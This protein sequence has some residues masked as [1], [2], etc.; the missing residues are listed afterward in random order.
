[1]HN[2][3]PGPSVP[4]ERGGEAGKSRWLWFSALIFIVS[5]YF[6]LHKVDPGGQNTWGVIAPA[7]ILSGYLLIIPAIIATYRR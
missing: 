3:G 2:G 5:G 1:M 6:L 4:A 7:L